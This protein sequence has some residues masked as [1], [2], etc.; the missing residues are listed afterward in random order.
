MYP[1]RLAVD[2]NPTTTNKRRVCLTRM[3]SSYPKVGVALVTPSAPRMPKRL[4]KRNLA[5]RPPRVKVVY[6]EI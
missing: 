3:K 6:A 4:E 5:K 1:N 2:K